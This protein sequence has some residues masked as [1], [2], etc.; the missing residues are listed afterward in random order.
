MP[1]LFFFLFLVKDRTYP[2]PPPPS[3]FQAA[4]DVLEDMSEAGL[5]MD[6]FTY[7]HAIEACCNA[8]N[9]VRKIKRL[10]T[11]SCDFFRFVV[12]GVV[13]L[14]FFR[15]MCVGLNPI[16]FDMV[17]P[18]ETSSTNISIY[19]SINQAYYIIRK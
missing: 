12:V 9:R 17:G 5:S 16:F 7:A 19:Q 8:G 18:A 10:A 1:V 15:G 11:Q 2:H 6:A 4:M 14:F 13:V 3:P